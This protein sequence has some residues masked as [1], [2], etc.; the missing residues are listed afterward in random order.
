M[1][2]IAHQ[3][4][5]HRMQPNQRARAA[6]SVFSFAKK[7]YASFSHLFR[8]FSFQNGINTQS[9]LIFSILLFRFLFYS[10]E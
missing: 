3:I 1:K 9:F 10:V 8:D 5:H 6:C 2:R 4:Q 7:E